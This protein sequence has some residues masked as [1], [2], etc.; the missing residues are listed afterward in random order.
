L[1]GR[2]STFAIVAAQA[3]YSSIVMSIPHSNASISLPLR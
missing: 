3:A 2:S 1:D